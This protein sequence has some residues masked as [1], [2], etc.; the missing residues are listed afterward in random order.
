M[1]FEQKKARAIALMDSKKMWRSNYAPPLLRILWRLGIRL[2]PLPFMPFWQVTLLM[3]SLWGISWG[4]A[5][6]F[7][8]YSA[9]FDHG[10]ASKS[11]QRFASIRSTGNLTFSTAF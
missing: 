11:D 10:L 6:W 7:I 2:P 9:L 5:M 1:T 4:C 3:G 8:A